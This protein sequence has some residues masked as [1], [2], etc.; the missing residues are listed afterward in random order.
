M[1]VYSKKHPWTE[2]VIH[3]KPAPSCDGGPPTPSIA[4]ACDTMPRDGG[5]A[6]PS[7]FSMHHSLP[8]D[9]GVLQ[10]IRR[11]EH[12]TYFVWRP[13]RLP[14]QVMQDSFMSMVFMNL[15]GEYNKLYVVWLRGPLC[16]IQKGELKPTSVGWT[17]RTS[18]N[19]RNNGDDGG[20]DCRGNVMGNGFQW[21]IFY[22]HLLQPATGS[23][24]PQRK[25]FS[26]QKY[27]N[28]M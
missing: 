11:P 18:S 4:L 22:L 2:R 3:H 1:I 25:F 19:K 7:C 16:T 28:M 17:L 6:H 10:V 23:C 9:G 8:G 13:S 27:Y 12:G 14:L 24:P 15:L 26:L 5:A 20:E 21:L